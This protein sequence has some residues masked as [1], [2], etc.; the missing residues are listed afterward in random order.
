MSQQDLLPVAEARQR[1]L[2]ALQPVPETEAVPLEQAYGRV[3][4][5]A[6]RTLYPLPPFTNSAM[7]GFAVRAADVA[8]AAPER[9]VV[10]Q[11]IGDAPAGHPFTGLVQPGQAVRITTGAPLPP[12][13]DAVVPVEDT[14]APDRTPGLPLPE[15]VTVYRAVA[16]GDFVRPAGQDAPAGAELLPSGRRL[17]PQDVALLAMAG[18]AEV[19]VYRRPRVA[20]L[21]SGDEL[22]AV[23]QPLTPGKIYDANTYTLRG[24]VASCGAE[25]LPLGIAPDRAEAVRERLEQAV[26]AGADLILTSAGVSV[27]AF[28]FVRQVITEQGELTFWRVN[29]RP[30]KPLAFGRYRGVPVIGLPGN[31]VS[32]F[33]GFEVF[34]R[35]ALEHLG[36]VVGWQRPVGV[37]RLEEGV[38]SDGRETFLRGVLRAEAAAWSVRPVGHQGSGDL[39]GLA[40]A[41]A[42]IRL[43]AGVRS[44]AAGE[45]V[46][47]WPLGGLF[48]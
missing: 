24:G 1:L 13:A 41:N 33:V 6:A 10:L 47:V 26:A 38:T 31:P 48:A 15:R 14:D 25:V 4:A 23:G 21:S 8:Q 40:Q 42:L 11:V 32:A 19:V 5:Q 18:V 12:G 35:P 20:V 45:G 30:G 28:D 2:A 29:M 9:P 16:P 44:A 46:E 7:D 17:R 34:V 37:A 36:G 39:F 3:L 27:G 22:L 43:P